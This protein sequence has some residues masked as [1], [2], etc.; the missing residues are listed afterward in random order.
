MTSLH[1]PI[2]KLIGS[3]SLRKGPREKVDL[4][5]GLPLATLGLGKAEAKFVNG[6]SIELLMESRANSVSNERAVM[7]WLG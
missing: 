6:I 2:E 7:P 3:R 4:E 1:P 5:D